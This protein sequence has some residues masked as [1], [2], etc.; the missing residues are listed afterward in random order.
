MKQNKIINAYNTMEQLANNQELT[1]HEQWALYNLRKK[2]RTHFEYQN[3]REAAIRAKYQQFANEE[4]MLNGVDANKYLTEMAE[5]NDME[6]ELEE[7]EKPKLRFV[8]GI[9]FETAEA[10]EDF[11]EFTPPD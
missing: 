11:I 10:L 4:G 7:F 2:L 3:E 6:I 5:L 1:E 8:K 9:S